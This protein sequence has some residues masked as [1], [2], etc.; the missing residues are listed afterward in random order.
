[1]ALLRSHRY[2]SHGIL[3]ELPPRRTFGDENYADVSRRLHTC[4]LI[5]FITIQMYQFTYRISI[6]NRDSS[7]SHDIRLCNLFSHNEVSIIPRTQYKI[8]LQRE[9]AHNNWDISNK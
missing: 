2:A 5:V 6:K 7:K 4:K 3:P 1:M 8:I 9:I